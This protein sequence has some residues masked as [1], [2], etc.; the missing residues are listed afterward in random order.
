MVED[1]LELKK[2]VNARFFE[3]RESLERKNSE[4][5]EQIEHLKTQ[6]EE[7]LS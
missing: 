4:V 2:T 1:F 5:L 6:K 3:L 7:Y